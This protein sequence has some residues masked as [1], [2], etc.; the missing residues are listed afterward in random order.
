MRDKEG[1]AI[2]CTLPVRAAS[3][4]GPLMVLEGRHLRSLFSSVGSFFFSLGMS[5]PLSLSTIPSRTSMRLV[6]G[7]VC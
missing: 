1:E 3:S 2:G 7:V 5:M 4:L 6:S